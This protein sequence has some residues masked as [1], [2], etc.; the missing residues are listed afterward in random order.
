MVNFSH[1]IWSIWGLICDF[2]NLFKS[3]KIFVNGFF[4]RKGAIVLNSNW[5][6][7]INV[8]LLSEY[9]DLR[10][11][12]KNASRLY[13]LLPVKNYLCIGSVLGLYDNPKMEVWGSGLIS[14]QKKVKQPIG[15]IWSVRGPLTKQALISQGIECPACFGDPALLVSR[16]YQPKVIKKYKLGIIPHYKDENNPAISEFI[17]G[18]N[19]VKIVSMSTYK[20]WRDIP[21]A[22][23]SCEFIISSSLHGL[24]VSDSYGVPNVW[25]KF[26]EEITGGSFKFLDYFA[27]VGRIVT[28]PVV[29][30]SS[31]DLAELQVCSEKFQ[32][33]EYI[34]FES[35]I[36]ACPFRKHLILLNNE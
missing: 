19:D 32:V 31:N 16:F 2:Y 8:S 33:A 17:K 18:R 5:G 14:A 7:D 34:D 25:A 30:S 9:S 20:N 29:I 15:K 23:C 13:R 28:S 22:V 36:N 10:I 6:D 3:P 21:N 11:L 26:S 24:I 27:S 4:S 12:P 35:I 1:I